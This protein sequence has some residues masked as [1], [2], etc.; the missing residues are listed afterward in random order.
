MVSFIYLFGSIAWKGPYLETLSPGKGKEAA[1]G[2]LVEASPALSL[3]SHNLSPSA[4]HFPSSSRT[5]PP[6]QHLHGLSSVWGWDWMVDKSL[7]L[8]FCMNSPGFP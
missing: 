5:L 1:T 8:C 6:T 2:G 4:P 3:H 7:G